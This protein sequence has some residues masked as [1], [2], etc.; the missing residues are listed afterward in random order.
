MVGKK[1]RSYQQGRKEEA[2]PVQ[3]IPLVPSYPVTHL[4]YKPKARNYKKKHICTENLLF[5]NTK[6]N[7]PK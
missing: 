2:V 3:L 7:T 6:K 1:I 4:T 5:V